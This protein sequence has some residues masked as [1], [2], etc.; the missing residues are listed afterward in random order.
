M[1]PTTMANPQPPCSSKTTMPVFDLFEIPDGDKL[2]DEEDA[3]AVV[4]FAR[5]HIVAPLMEAAGEVLPGMGK[6]CTGVDAAN[7]V[8]G[9]QSKEQVMQKGDFCHGRELGDSD[10]KLH[11]FDLSCESLSL[12]FSPGFCLELTTTD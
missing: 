1:N 11:R 2:L 7:K 5:D 3:W 12:Y 6:G 4:E 9:R 10:V 8:G